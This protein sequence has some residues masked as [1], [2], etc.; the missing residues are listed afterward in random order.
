MLMPCNHPRT[1][2][3]GAGKTTTINCL[4]GVLSPTGGDALVYGESISNEGGMDRIRSIMGVCP[5]F[6]VLWGELTGAEHLGIYG[7]IKGLPFA[8][9][10]ACG[11]L[12]EGRTK[13]SCWLA[14]CR[15]APLPAVC[16]SSH[17]RLSSHNFNQLGNSETGGR[18]SSTQPELAAHMSRQTRALQLPC[19]ACTH[20][21]A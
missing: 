1:G 19:P 16:A 18:L 13:L 20:H 9:V 2:P 10:R 5:Q 7:H 6:D 14:R 21:L 3:N 4:T 12:G 8:E 11:C 17:D 15:N